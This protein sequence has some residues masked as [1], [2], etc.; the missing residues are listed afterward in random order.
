MELER[1]ARSALAESLPHIMEIYEGLAAHPVPVSM[2]GT[3]LD[4][5]RAELEAEEVKRKDQRRATAAGAW[6]AALKTA[7]K[8][9]DLLA[10]RKAAI[11]RWGAPCTG[12]S[13]AF[14]LFPRCSPHLD[15]PLPLVAFKSPSPSFL[16]PLLFDL[17]LR[18]SLGPY[19]ALGT[20]TAAVSAPHRHVVAMPWSQPLSWAMLPALA[21]VRCCRP[22]E[23]RQCPR[24][25]GGRLR[26]A[27]GDAGLAQG[28]HWCLLALCVLLYTKF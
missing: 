20:A 6:M 5:L 7:G 1:E 27:A 18:F 16:P 19:C 12:H 21:L 23:Q 15:L 4:A 28:V 26:G 13:P 24:C 11:P 25:D 22:S 10:Y 2:Q 9:Y 14:S 17:G 3:L 8:S